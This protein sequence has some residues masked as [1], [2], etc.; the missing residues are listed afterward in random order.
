MN[1]APS[2]ASFAFADNTAR[3]ERV[4]A[5]IGECALRYGLSRS[6][7]KSAVKVKNCV[8]A[9]REAAWQ[10]AKETDYS[11]PAIGKFLAKDHTTI[12]HCIRRQ[13]TI[14]G[15]NVRGLGGISAI[16]QERDRANATACHD[17]MTRDREDEAFRHFR[18]GK[19]TV[20]IALAMRCRPASAANALARARDRARA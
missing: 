1:A 8:A 12:I 20:S 18:A 4:P 10:I 16:K 6:D 13:N 11:L 14:T 9:R 2:P 7:L 19:D 5:I 17:L 15:E 3:H